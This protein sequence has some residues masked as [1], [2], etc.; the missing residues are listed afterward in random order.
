M[1]FIQTDLS[2]KT[3]KIL[4]TINNPD[5]EG[6]VPN[7]CLFNGI[8]MK[9]VLNGDEKNKDWIINSI[10]KY[11]ENT[12][13]IK[14]KTGVYYCFSLEIGKEG[15]LHIHIFF[16]FENPR[17][18]NSIKKFFPT[19]HI[20]YCNGSSSSVRDYVFKTGK[21]EG[22]EKEDTRIDGLQY[23][24]G[25]LPEEKGQGERTDLEMIKDLIDS[26]LSPQQILDSDP[27]RYRL[28]GYI[29]KMYFDKRKKETPLKR[30]VEVTI[31]TGVAGS[32]KSN[33][34][35]TLDEN[36]MFIATDYSS[37]LFDNFCGEEILFLDEFRGQ[38]PYNQLLIMLDGYKVPI[39]ARYA[40]VLSVWN[41]VHITSVI[42][43][44]E[45][46]HNDNI[47]DTFEQLKRRISYITYH[48]MT[49]KNAVITDKMLFLKNH[50]K[51][52]IEYHEYTIRAEQYTSYEELEREALNAANIILKYN[53]DVE[54]NSPFDD[55]EVPTLE[56][57]Y[58]D[59]IENDYEDYVKNHGE[60]KN[61]ERLDLFLNIKKFQAKIEVA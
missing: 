26:G 14:G 41:S 19:A 9:E 60:I 28:E 23:E 29:R 58:T 44:E 7:S 57:E 27:N 55:D 46:Y 56:D 12:S 31:H 20:D 35:T 1:K 50:N 30:D 34:L 17:F 42:P 54:N 39:H 38:I 53:P 10:R 32:G 13:I 61:E 48:Y 43:I 52:E 59:W 36:Q 24:N 47:R 45:W 37:A 8:A 4:L 18:G 40:N 5:K 3:R 25:E 2:K 33:V 21:W 49:Y 51:S 16:W 22:D 6:T 15:T 11:I